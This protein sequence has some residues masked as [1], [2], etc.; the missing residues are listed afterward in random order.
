M[1]FDQGLAQLLRED[2]AG[3]AVVEKKMFGG[4]CFLAQGNMI[5]GLHKGGTMYRVG[6][7]RY[8]QALALPGV[9]PM[10]MGAR[11]MAAMVMLSLGDSADDRLRGPVLAM[12]LETVR[13]LPPKVAK[14][15]K[16]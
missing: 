9:Q 3:E 4:L 14:P 2:L 7:D 11:T 10:Q 12:A 15:K 13:A 1:A 8:D 16:G 6:K 5:C